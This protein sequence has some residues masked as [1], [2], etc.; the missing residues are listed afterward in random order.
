MRTARAEAEDLKG[1]GVWGRVARSGLVT[2]YDASRRL[3]GSPALKLAA[4]GRWHG[5]SYSGEAD[6]LLGETRE[7]LPIGDQSRQACLCVG[8]QARDEK[9]RRERSEST[10]GF[11][12][13]ACPCLG[14]TRGDPAAVRSHFVFSGSWRFRL[15]KRDYM[16]NHLVFNNFVALSRFS[17]IFNHICSS[18]LP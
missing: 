16:I 13:W 11:S 9:S 5:R 15:E 4:S 18:R 6:L 10:P 2:E 12:A 7:P 17:T 8:R 3:P 14:P 1:F